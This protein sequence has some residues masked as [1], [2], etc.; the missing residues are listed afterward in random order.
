MIRTL[1]AGAI[2]IVPLAAAAAGT[3]AEADLELF[4]SFFEGEFNNHGQV[5]DEVRLPASDRH[6]WHH[7]TVQRVDV[8]AF[9][10]RVFLA[11]I[12]EEGPHGALVRRRLFVIE[13][14]PAHGVIRQRFFALP[15]E[16]PADPTDLRWLTPDRVQGYPPGCEI[17]WKRQIDQ[18][19]GH[20]ALGACRVI[21][22]RSGNTV[23]I[24]ADMDLGAGGMWHR[25]EGYRE[26]G[27]PLFTA[28]GGVPF[29]LER[30]RPFTCAIRRADR[31]GDGVD[32]QL[33]DLGGI[34]TISAGA[35]R[36]V[37]LERRDSL[38]LTISGTDGIPLAKATTDRAAT[39]IGIEISQ[40]AVT[41][42]R[43]PR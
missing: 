1:V 15:N 25:E 11:Q 28:P 12:N 33:H 20:M 39:R 21:S 23:R 2:A 3:T 18:F 37:R 19:H 29:K 7:H 14:D 36:I 6:P 31:E 26:D 38:E 16:Q 30:T 24:V 17:Q 40:F 35:P 13:P 42:A 41:C 5:L 22:P 32:V 10:T 4:L 34:A 43:Q 27:T 9:G 8:P